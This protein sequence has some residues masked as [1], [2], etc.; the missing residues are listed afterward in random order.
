[1]KIAEIP[2]EIRPREKAIRYGID[3]ISDDELLA[4]LIG[5]GVKGCSAL[6]IA[7]NLLAV[8]TGLSRLSNCDYSSLE[9]QTGLSSISVIKLLA[10]FELHKRL[11][12]PL[13]KTPDF[14]ADS[15]EI[16][17]RYNYLENYNQETVILLMLN[18]KKK[19]L[20]EKVLYRGTNENV[21]VNPKEIMSE[22]IKSNC[23]DYI[24]VHNHPDGSFVA[25]DEDF[26]VTKTLEEIGSNLQ[27]R[28]VDHIIIFPGGYYSFRDN[29][30]I[31]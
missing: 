4:I 18:K 30:I 22:I 26:Y 29:K 10:A 16:Y 20:K 31:K 13:Y 14:T 2:K 9:E 27:I 7:R 12:S 5:S 28:M 8:H 25:S 11:S 24:L 3:S 15:K 17:E 6:D 21:L 23:S 1:M 19:V